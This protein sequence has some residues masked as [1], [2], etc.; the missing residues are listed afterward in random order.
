MDKNKENE[1]LS[2]ESF[3]NKLLEQMKANKDTTNSNEEIVVVS[4][5]VPV[6]DVPIFESSP[7]E[8]SVI[9]KEN[10]EETSQENVSDI[11]NDSN[12]SDDTSLKVENDSVQEQELEEKSAIPEL[13][14]PALK[15][16][17]E[18]LKTYAKRNNNSSTD[19]DTKELNN[20]SG[21]KDM[22]NESEDKNLSFGNELDDKSEKGHDETDESIK[23]HSRRAQ[24]RK[25]KSI[26]GKIIATISVILLILVAVAGFLGYRFWSTSTMPLDSKSTT[27]KSVEIPEGSGNKLIGNILEKNGIIKSATVFQ[28]YTKFKSSGNFKSGYYN[29]SPSMN[30]DEISDKLVEGGTEKPQEP[31]LGKVVIP[32][33]YT[34]EQIA[35]AITKNANSKNKKGKTPFSKDEF[36][37]VLTDDNFINKMKE[38]YP[39]MMESLPDKK[40]VKYQLEG[41]LFPA[42]YDYT[43]NTTV[44][45][46]AEDM[47][48]TMN[49]NLSPYYDEIKS[50]SLT[51]NEVLSLS[52]LV[53]KEGANDEDRRM[54]AQVFY[55]RLNAGM[56]LQS[57]IAILYA[58]GK[59]GQKTSLKEDAA[60]DTNIDSPYNLYVHTGFGPG[61][62]ANPGIAAIKAV[63]NPKAND[64]LFFV[65][66]V[67]TGKVYY[68]R[69]LA[70]H[71]EQVQKYVNDQIN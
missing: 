68:S 53:E 4:E 51:V 66:D 35:E 65:A 23:S 22:D 61:P 20:L 56:P 1:Q 47:L 46:L 16:K 42:T 54:I 71:E 7:N 36:I 8:E 40:D 28:Y 52:A 50:K 24:K 63:M 3:K 45:S 57:N 27:Y 26:A 14:E 38:K 9:K 29:F 2:Q 11:R 5:D 48:F 32:E 58:E 49:T 25:Q 39:L 15:K 12:S 69:T 37:K 6:E 67:S 31:V 43:K 44:E 17:D 62:V 59:S 70:E 33:G 60:I 30:L 18:A 13:T 55:N 21:S 19:E 41:Y 64:Y 10:E 34:L